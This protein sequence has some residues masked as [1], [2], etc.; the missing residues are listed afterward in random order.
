MKQLRSVVPILILLISIISCTRFSGSSN[1]PMP[2]QIVDL[3][4]FIGKSH[5]EITKMVGSPP[6]KDSSTD[7]DWELPEGT[8][9]VRKQKGDTDQITY[10]LKKPYSGFASSPEMAALANIDITRRKVNEGRGLQS[11]D[12]ISVNGYTFD[13]TLDNWGGRYP[14]ARMTNIRAGGR[15]PEG[16]KPTQVV[17]LPAMIGK[18]RPEITKMVGISPYKDE[19]IAADWQLPEG[20]LTDFDTLKNPSIYYKLNSYSDFDPGRGVASPEEMAALVRID[21]QGRQPETIQDGSLL[22][23]DLSVNGKTLDLYIYFEKSDKRYMGVSIS[24]FK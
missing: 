2:T 3:P 17:D 20:R 9:T 4:S 14:L 8:L 18:S 15:V 5:E 16:F 7:T 24:N 23:R 11:Y 13:L 12:N 10:L 22:Y 1:G 19:N 6:S 21:L